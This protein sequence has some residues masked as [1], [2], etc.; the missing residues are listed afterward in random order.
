[1]AALVLQWFTHVEYISDV[2]F[3]HAMGAILMDKKAFE[4]IDASNQSIL[5]EVCKSNLRSLVERSR[6]EN[7]E[8][9]VQLSKEGLEKVVSTVDQRLKLRL[10]GERVNERLAETLYSHDLLSRID[11][12]LVEYRKTDD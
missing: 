12:L 4:K 8:A 9:Y 2:P 7:Q 5:L 3:T 11:S 6:I 1:M 10:I